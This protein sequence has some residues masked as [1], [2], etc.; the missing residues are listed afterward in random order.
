MRLSYVE[1]GE[2]FTVMYVP[3]LNFKYVHFEF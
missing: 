2:G 1:E 3:N